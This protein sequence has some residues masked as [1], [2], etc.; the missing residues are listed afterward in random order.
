MSTIK[1]RR[2]NNPDHVRRLLSEQINI[3]RQDEALEPIEKARAIAYLSNVLLSA[4]KDGEAM[5]KIDEIQK[6][7]EEMGV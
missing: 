5:K 1:N 3:L 7:L 2:I 6:Q 4:Y